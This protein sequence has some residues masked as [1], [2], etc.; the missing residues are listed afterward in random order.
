MQAVDDLLAT[1]ERVYALVAH[2][3]ADKAQELIDDSTEVAGCD[4]KVVASL[5]DDMGAMGVT[6]DDESQVEK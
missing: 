5:V 6:G 4:C 3:A 1:V 2:A